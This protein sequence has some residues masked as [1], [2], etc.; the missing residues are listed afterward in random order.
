MA[1]FN[2]KMGFKSFKKHTVWTTLA[3]WK[4]LPGVPGGPEYAFGKVELT[5]Q[6]ADLMIDNSYLQKEKH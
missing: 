5:V 2:Y 3:V 4:P 6:S 1:F